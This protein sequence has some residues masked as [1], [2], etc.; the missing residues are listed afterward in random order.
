[1]RAAQFPAPGDPDCSHRSHF[2]CVKCRRM[3]CAR[4]GSEMAGPSDVWKTLHY[5]CED[6]LR[7]KEADV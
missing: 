1:V 6:C 2:E 5:R 4:C 3:F 7:K